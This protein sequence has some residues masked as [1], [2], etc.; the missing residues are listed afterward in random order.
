MKNKIKEGRIIFPKNGDGSPLLKRFQNEAKSDVIPVSTWGTDLKSSVSNSFIT[1][2]NTEG[3]K[4]IK[5]LFEN[6]VFTFPKPTRLIKSL[7]DQGCSSDGLVLDFFAGSGT[8]ADAVM[9]LNAEDGGNRKFILIQIPEQCDQNS[10]AFKSGFK[11]ISDIGKE[12]IR[13]AGTAILSSD[14][15]ESWKKDVGFRVM[16]IDSSNMENV[17][18]TPDSLIQ[19]NLMLFSENIKSGRTDE[20]LLFQ[21]LLDW[22]IDISLSVEKRQI[23]GKNVFFVDNDSLLACFEKD[24][25]EEIIHDLEKVRLEKVKSLIES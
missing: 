16:K 25:S 13:R 19:K 2:L 4:E 5:K 6:K 22:G 18:Y 3:T 24:I 7:L 12:R 9:Q 15:H 1:A 21:V 8:T 20:D 10:E 23:L 14:A 17:C 11:T